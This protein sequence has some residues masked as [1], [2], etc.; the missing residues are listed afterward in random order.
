MTHPR[1]ALLLILAVD[2]IHKHMNLLPYILSPILHLHDIK[3]IRFEDSFSVHVRTIAEYRFFFQNGSINVE[4]RFSVGWIYNYRKSV[5]ITLP[6]SVVDT[7]IDKLSKVQL[8]ND[9][10]KSG[11]FHTGGYPYYSIR[12]FTP[13][14]YTAFVS[15]SQFIHRYPWC[16]ITQGKQYR[17]QSY[18]PNEAFELIQSYV[19][20]HK[21]KAIEEAEVLFSRELSKLT[22]NKLFADK[23]KH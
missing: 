10:C 13:T 15:D 22:N 16:V 20:S 11:V 4:G 14:G 17:N 8:I 1:F 18:L 6:E 2:G 21:D 12:I 23:L 7:V 3:E 19:K 5:N 9:A